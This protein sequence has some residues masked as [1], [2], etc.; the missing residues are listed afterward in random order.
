MAIGNDLSGQFALDVQ[1][2]QRL[3]H[4]A[5]NAPEESLHEAAR[6]FE[7]VFLQMMLK[8]MREAS[9]QSGLMHSQQM[10]TMQS[11]QDQ[12]WAQVLAGKGIGLAEQL[13][14]QLQGSGLPGTS[15]GKTAANE[16]ISSLIAGIPRGTPRVLHDGLRI[17]S[18]KS[19][20]AHQNASRQMDATP[21]TGAADSAPQTHPPHVAAFV[22]QLAEPAQRAERSSGVPASL[23]LAQAALETGWG[24]REIPT[25]SGGNSHNLFG[26]KA[27]SSWDGETTTIT[28]TEYV[29]G[30]P[31][32]IADRF[33]VYD[34]YADAFADYAQ[35]IGNN[36][37][38]RGVTEAGSP[39]AAAVALQQG[40]YATDPRYAEKLHTIMGQIGPLAPTGREAL[41]AD[42]GNIDLF[43]PS[44]VPSAIF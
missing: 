9:P 35:L 30:R 4:K 6:Q 13:V 27:G 28:T 11:M 33:R 39:K 29:A 22:D 24:Q 12:Q 2:V 16:E 5:A 42:A 17:P 38:Y 7:A 43:G 41:M 40:G 32:K 1:S 15:G 44:R 10:D 19:E 14:A 37:R 36:P 23:I 18:P 31:V 34:S 21:S 20:L 3:R 26:I 8:S 25:A